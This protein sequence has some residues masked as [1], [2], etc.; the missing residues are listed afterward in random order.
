MLSTLRRSTLFSTTADAYQESR[1]KIRILMCLF[2]SYELSDL[3]DLPVMHPID[4]IIQHQ[5]KSATDKVWYKFVAAEFRQTILNQQ[6]VR[7][8]FVKEME[9]FNIFTVKDA[10]LLLDA[11]LTCINY[12]MHFLNCYIS[13]NK[14]LTKNR[15]AIHP[16]EPEKEF[17]AH[18]IMTAFLEGSKV[19][20]K[21]QLVTGDII[22]YKNNQMNHIGLYIGEFAGESYVISKTGNL[23]ET[24][25]HPLYAATDTYG[26]PI[27]YRGFYQGK[28]T[29]PEINSRFEI[30]KQEILSRLKPRS[31]NTP[32][33]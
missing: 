13:V 33:G 9:K 10:G 5:E 20:Q 24:T 32:R 23:H 31:T 29:S 26:D 15:H 17:Y 22:V 27:F 30:A 3:A 18:E 28:S 19:I 16:N 11:N 6:S 25:I 1:N 12:V 2:E 8:W 4:V 21:N 14:K 7:E